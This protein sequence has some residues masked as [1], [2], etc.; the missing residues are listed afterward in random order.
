MYLDDWLVLA[1]SFGLCES[2]VQRLIEISQSLGFRINLAKSHVIPSTEFSYLGM[3]L[4]T[5]AWTVRPKE[6]RLLKLSALLR[7]LLM[8]ETASARR[9]HTLLGQMESLSLLLPLARVFKRPLQRALADRWDQ[10]QQDWDQEIPLGGWFN[11]SVSQWLDEEWLSS[12]VPIS[13]RESPDEVFTDASLSGWGAHFLD[14]FAQGTWEES[15]SDKHINVLEM[16]AVQ[17]AVSQF[18]PFF[19]TTHVLVVSD[20]TTVVAYLNRQGGT[21]SRELSLLTED[22]LKSLYAKGIF[23]SARHLA[24]ACNVLADALSRQDKI[25]NTEWT[26]SHQALHQVWEAWGK[27]HV[28]L[29][30]TKFSTRLPIYV[31]PVPDPSAW[32]VD[33][34]SFQWTALDLYAFPPFPLIRAVL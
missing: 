33:A 16:M 5:V 24:G 32:R 28:D 15:L 12:S 3:T 13:F 17:R 6:S 9:L 27:P 1:Q 8:A 14:H 25:L 2:H 31:S 34:M 10:V 20:N 4:D 18:L 7:E 26:L 30:A 23:L 11:Q 21:V 22:L 19:Q 29:F